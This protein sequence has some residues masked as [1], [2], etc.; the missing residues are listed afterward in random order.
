[1]RLVDADQVKK[2][3]L[4][5]CTNLQIDSELTATLLESVDRLP[6]AYD[7]KHVVQKIKEWTFN[8]DVNI[9]DGSVVNKDLIC[10]SIAID[11]VTE[12]ETE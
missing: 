5:E 6:T 8:A 2:L 11:I 10:S 4:K 12:G 9:G 7:T 3:I 1:M